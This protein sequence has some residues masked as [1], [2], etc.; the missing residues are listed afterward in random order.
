MPSWEIVSWIVL[1]AVSGVV[2]FLTIL[3]VVFKLSRP[4]VHTV[5]DHVASMRRD[6]AAEAADPNA[7]DAMTWYSE[8]RQETKRPEYKRPSMMAARFLNMGNR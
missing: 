3:L 6:I 1:C 7:K 5:Q 4:G 8:W 2:I